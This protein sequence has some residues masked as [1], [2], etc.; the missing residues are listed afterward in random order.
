MPDIEMEEFPRGVLVVDDEPMILQLLSQ[1]LAAKEL[2][3]RTAASAEEAEAT[4]RK[5]AIGCLLVDKNL[6][7][8]DGLELLRRT[9]ALQPQ[10]ACL[11]MTGYASIDSAVEALRLGAAD[12]V[13][14]PFPSLQLVA[15]KVR[16][17]LDNA[18]ARFERE[19]FLAQLRAFEA[20]LEKRHQQID[21]QR[22][23]I[24]IFNDVL[25]ARVAVAE[26]DL[27]KR[28]EMLSAQLASKMGGD[29][30]ARLSAEMVLKVAAGLESRPESAPLRGELAR[31]V[32]QLEDHLTLLG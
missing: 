23:E 31:I 12:Y 2:S 4:L 6:P 15:E 3:V 16:L 30:A 11:V 7:G 18:Q 32:R 14:K 19:R 5:D 20:E 1:A 21:Q 26:G 10:A 24:E 8:M 29:R 13:Q 25:E 9:R 27:R 17:A 22:T 28:C